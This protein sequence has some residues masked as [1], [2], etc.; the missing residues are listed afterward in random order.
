MAKK[1]LMKTLG[2][3]ELIKTLADA[4]KDLFTHRISAAGARPKDTNALSKARKTIARALTEM[5][6]RA[7][8]DSAATAK[9]V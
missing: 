8:N 3:A 5:R 1:Q 6:A 9:T 7:Q 2:D 4:R